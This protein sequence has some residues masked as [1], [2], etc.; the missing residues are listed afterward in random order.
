MPDLI[1]GLL[2]GKLCYQ[3]YEDYLKAVAEAICNY[4][5]MKEKCDQL[6]FE[7]DAAMRCLKAHGI[8]FCARG[9]CD[10]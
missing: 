1:E 2:S 4:Q 5:S 8:E 6:Q 7:R 9:G 3:N 10:V